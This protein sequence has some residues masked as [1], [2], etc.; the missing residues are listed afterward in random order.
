MRKFLSHFLFFR[1]YLTSLLPSP[2]CSPHL[3]TI[4]NQKAVTNTF[5]L[6]EDD[7]SYT[8][9]LPT[10]LAFLPCI[11]PLNKKLAGFYAAEKSS[12]ENRK[13][14]RFYCKFNGFFFLFKTH[15]Q[16]M[17]LKKNEP[18]DGNIT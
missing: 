4:Y 5:R 10:V 2:F 15:R 12:Q 18:H 9:S 8:S 13:K 11:W 1:T 6:L 3:F 7:F 16:E 14:I 17:M